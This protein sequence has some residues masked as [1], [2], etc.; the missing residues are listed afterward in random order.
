MLSFKVKAQLNTLWFD[1]VMMVGRMYQF[2][3]FMDIFVLDFKITLKPEIV[4]SSLSFTLY[5]IN[6]T[7]FIL[8][9]LTNTTVLFIKNEY[10]ATFGTK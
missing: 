7:Q 1:V 2:G 8:N 3:F 4:Y 6:G 10:L 9:P 5:F